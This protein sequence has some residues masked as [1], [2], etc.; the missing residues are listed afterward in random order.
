VLKL[1]KVNRDSSCKNRVSQLN[2]IIQHSV[3]AVECRSRSTLIPRARKINKYTGAPG[4]EYEVRQRQRTMQTRS[5]SSIINNPYGEGIKSTSSKDQIDTMDAQK[6]GRNEG[7]SHHLSQAAEAED[8]PSRQDT[9]PPVGQ[10]DTEDARLIRMMNV[11]QTLAIGDANFTPKPFEGN[12][13]DTERTD[14]W[15][16]YF[17]KYT[18]F[19]G[20]DDDAKLNLL[21]LLLTGQAAE[22]VR[23]LPID[24][25]TD[26]QRLITEFRRRFSL[27]DI[28]RWQKAT[29]MW[30]REQGASESVDAYITDIINMA[31]VVPVTDKELIRFAIVK[32]L[33][34][35]IKMHVLQS[36]ATTID[37]VTKTARVSEAAQIASKTDTDVSAL[38][39]QV[40]DLIQMMKANASTVAAVENQSKT[41]PT[42]PARRVQFDDRREQ[43]L[44]DT[45]KPTTPPSY[46]RAPMHD[47]YNAQHQDTRPDM[48]RWQ[49]EARR[50]EQP[51]FQ[52]QQGQRYPI[53]RE[54][55]TGYSRLQ[56]PAQRCENC[57]EIHERFSRNCRSFRVT[58]YACNRIGH[59]ARFCKYA[60]Y[61][62]NNPPT[63][64]RSSR[65]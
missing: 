36:G 49:A 3:I 10:H 35:A 37:D 34:P 11:V 29:S 31:R 20:I 62:R 51:R 61:P 18:S 65:P 38:A 8:N 7:C 2:N 41:R 13:R 46:R 52:R 44:R 24:V 54:Y 63:Q 5:T 19:R 40:A 27:T 50:P 6:S 33:K 47:D 45:R 64:Y 25:T 26:I 21:K 22:W 9:P 56:Q 14:R 59:F 1:I 28:N 17:E 48:D 16:E 15:L 30:T 4:G 39:S 42:S 57:G 60:Q 43:E 12:D 23:S 53:E 32:G 58:C 55:Q